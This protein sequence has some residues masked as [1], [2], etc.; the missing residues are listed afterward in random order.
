MGLSE[1]TP[2]GYLTRSGSFATVFTFVRR[3]S[4]LYACSVSVFLPALLSGTL[5][6]FLVD[7]R[8][9][10]ARLVWGSCYLHISPYW[11][12]SPSSP[13]LF[14]TGTNLLLRPYVTVRFGFLTQIL[15]ILGALL[16]PSTACPPSL[17]RLRDPKPSYYYLADDR[18]LRV[19]FAFGLLR[20]WIFYLFLARLASSLQ[21]AFIGHRVWCPRQGPP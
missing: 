8:S 14:A 15:G 11:N 10:S 2:P 9:V 13:I 18:A 4:P 20:R 19:R 12:R 16:K 21:S 1:I 5:H 6:A 7:R 17:R 3:L